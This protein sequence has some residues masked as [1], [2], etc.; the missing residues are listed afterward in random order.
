MF[1]FDEDI[2]TR[3][4]SWIEQLNKS[5]ETTAPDDRNISHY[6]K[7]QYGLFR[8]SISYLTSWI[9]NKIASLFLFFFHSKRD[10]QW[11]YLLVDCQIGWSCFSHFFSFSPSSSSSFFPTRPQPTSGRLFDDDDSASNKKTHA[12]EREREEEARLRAI[13]R[14]PSI[15]NHEHGKGR[16]ENTAIL[17]N[18]GQIESIKRRESVSKKH[19]LDQLICMGEC[20]RD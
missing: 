16:T 19:F 3:N 17:I 18:D 5:E 10:V 20:E 6:W 9:A 7:H 2:F 14:S 15:V 4:G 8:H 13:G 12:R 1:F 11:C